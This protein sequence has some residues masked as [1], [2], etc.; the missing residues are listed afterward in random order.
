MPRRKRRAGQQPPS[1]DDLAQRMRRLYHAGQLDAAA[2]VARTL[3]PH[4]HKP[5]G[6]AEA[7]L[8]EGVQRGDPQA[9]VGY[10]RRYAQD[11]G[12]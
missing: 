1:L 5:V 4:F 9:I 10:L 12:Y 7:D 6:G 11:R 8:V 3:L 2:A